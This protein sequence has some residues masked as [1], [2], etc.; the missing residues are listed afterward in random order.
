MI[1]V[2]PLLQY[3]PFTSTC[4]TGLKKQGLLFS[5]KKANGAKDHLAKRKIGVTTGH[6]DFIS[7]QVMPLI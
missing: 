7:R 6:P 4:Q 2:F 5:S 3:A 1:S